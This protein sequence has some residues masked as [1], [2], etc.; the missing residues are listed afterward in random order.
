VT[1]DLET[2]EARALIEARLGRPPDDAYE[3]AVVLEAWGGERAGTVFRTGSEAV[4]AAGPHTRAEGKQSAD[5]NTERT[6]AD[7]IATLLAVL[8]IAAWSTPL[9]QA[10]GS[11][12]S[13]A[14]GV[15]L[16]LALAAQWAVRSRYR[17]VSARR[18]V[19]L[20]QDLPRVAV[21]TVAGAPAAWLALG[22]AGLVA[23]LL[24]V[25][26]AG[27]AVIAR[28]GRAWLQAAVVGI[29]G[30]ALNLGAPVLVVLGAAAAATLAAVV[31]AAL[32][33]DP[34]ASPGPGALAFAGAASG[35]LL[36]LLLTADSTIRWGSAWVLGVTLVPSV[37]AALWAGAHLATLHVR[38][39]DDLS[40]VEPRRAGSQLTALRVLGGA[41]ARYLGCCAVLSIAVGLFVTSTEP[42]IPMLMLAFGIVGILSTGVA[43]LEALGWRVAAVGSMATAYAIA[44]GIAHAGQGAAGE[45]IVVGAA[46]GAVVA[47][48][49]VV[50]ALSR[51]AELLATRLWIL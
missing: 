45:P 2:T 40:G 14:F 23:S 49:C 16:P 15:A 50:A 22:R 17:I 46:V 19:G 1:P 28:A 3:A 48:S 12:E 47:V 33:E 8:G 10:L 32:R 7:G 26:W 13:A 44:V 5:A 35:L 30:F 9:A 4:R 36:G 11:D 41:A 39:V 21:A 42:S 43:F 25:I 31:M 51:P 34:D 24:V 27:G 37:L 18:L 6:P 20:R 38:L 29:V